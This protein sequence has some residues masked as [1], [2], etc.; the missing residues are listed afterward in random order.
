[1]AGAGRA[2]R[3]QQR[4]LMTRL[5]RGEIGRGCRGS[6]PVGSHGRRSNAW[7]AAHVT[8]QSAH[9]APAGPENDAFAPHRQPDHPPHTSGEAARKP[10][11]SSLRARRGLCVEGLLW[12]SMEGCSRG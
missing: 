11:A 7:A 3:S 1:M 10:I 8:P 9:I 12:V 5:R 6:R 4:M 2:C